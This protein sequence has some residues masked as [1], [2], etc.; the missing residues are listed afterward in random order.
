MIR[1]LLFGRS[2]RERYS[3]AE[4]YE[5]RIRQYGDIHSCCDYDMLL[6]HR[7]LSREHR[8]CSQKNVYAFDN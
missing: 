3:F 2:Q 6:V 4:R 1:S 7:A 8:T 5:S